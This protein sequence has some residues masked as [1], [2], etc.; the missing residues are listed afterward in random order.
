MSNYLDLDKLAEKTIKFGDKKYTFKI[1]PA[2]KL[3]KLVKAGEAVSKGGGIEKVNEKMVPAY[4]ELFP[5]LPK[6]MYKNFTIEQ[7]FAFIRL[8]RGTDKE[9]ETEAKKS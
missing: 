4:Q 3:N 5:T 9:E 2:S 1:P 8:I 6:E 7:H